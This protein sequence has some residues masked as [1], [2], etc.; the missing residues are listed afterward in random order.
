MQRVWDSHSCMP[1]LPPARDLADS[2]FARRVAK[3]LKREQ[4]LSK[5]DL[6][7]LGRALH[8][9]NTIFEGKKLL[10]GLSAVFRGYEPVSEYRRALKVLEDAKFKVHSREQL[11][12]R[13]AAVHDQIEAVIKSGKTAPKLTKTAILFFE[14]VETCASDG[15]FVGSSF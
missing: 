8:R 6:E 11:T 10:D 4:P 3:I 14:G 2:F 12:K 7:V 5:D 15:S 9:V 13:L 1:P